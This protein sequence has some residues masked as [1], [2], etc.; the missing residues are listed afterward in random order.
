MAYCLLKDNNS[1]I[2]SFCTITIVSVLSVICASWYIGMNK[3]MRQNLVMAI[4]KKLN[5]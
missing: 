4:Q 1:T 2:L 5:H 3:A